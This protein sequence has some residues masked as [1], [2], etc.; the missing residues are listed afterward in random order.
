MIAG[1][2][3]KAFVLLVLFAGGYLL[4]RYAMDIS[5]KVALIVACGVM[6][7]VTFLVW[8]SGYRGKRFS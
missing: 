4:M 2:F 3:Y 1:F 8:L 7:A 5:R 6:P